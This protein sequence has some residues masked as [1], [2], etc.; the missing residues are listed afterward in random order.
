MKATSIVEFVRDTYKTDEFIPLH[1]PTFN[2]NEK[3]Y[4]METIDSTFV[5]SVGKFVDDFERKVEA[6]TG[7]A[8][9]V[10]TVNGTAAL[11]AAL[12]MADVQRG[13]LVIT[14]A[15]TFV[16]TCNALYHMGAEP[17][18]VD[19]SPVSLG[20]CPKAVDAFLSEHAEITEA[21]CI[22]K[23]TGKRIKAVVPMHTFGHPVELDELV[24]VCLKWNLVLVEDAAESLGSF[25]KGQHT[26]TM[27]D[28]SALSFNGNKIITTGGGG[29][30]LCKTEELGA[31]TKHVTTTAKVP[32][33]YEFF[34]DEPG[35]NYRMPNLNAALGCAQMEVIEQYLKQKQQLA[36]CYEN[37]FSRTDFQFVTEPD[38]AES[39]YW[40]NAIIC[41]DKKSREEI[42]AGTNS[43]GVMT[44]PIWQ[45]MHRLPMF[46]NAMR[47]D[48]TYSEFIEAHLINLPST[49]V[50]I[51]S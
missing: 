8:K 35:F 31:R 3:A 40:L 49:P 47:G 43:A 18:F 34:H 1:A 16:A 23:Q 21:G 41:P 45:L 24:V 39:N 27:G 48:L 19:V 44:R 6:Y 20:L 4:V 13:D 42:L 26:G 7:T 33:P 15:L 30:V 14:Q 11:H 25:Y 10:A 22:H 29:M 51:K 38:Y 50:E 36:K 32:H 2:G 46:E 28:V 17:I 5:S 9:A 12:Y 37:L